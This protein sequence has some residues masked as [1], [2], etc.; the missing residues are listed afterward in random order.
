[1]IEQKGTSKSKKSA[2]SKK[3]LIK[4][5]GPTAVDFSLKLVRFGPTSS[6]SAF[7]SA[8]RMALE[9]TKGRILRT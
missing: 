5:G 2:H 4:S 1:M 8:D 3:N 6:F 7:R 9:D